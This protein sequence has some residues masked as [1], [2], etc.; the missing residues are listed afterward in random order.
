MPIRPNRSVLDAIPA[1]RWV[2]T[3]LGRG[4]PGDGLGHVAPGST[5]RRDQRRAAS[6]P[7]RWRSTSRR[8]ILFHAHRL[9]RLPEYARVRDWSVRSAFQP[10]IL[11]GR[12]LGLLGYGGVGRRAAHIA[13][14]LGMRVLAVRRS[15]GRSPAEQFRRPEIDALDAGPEPAEIRGLDALD[16]LL[17]SSDLLRFNGAA[18]GRDARA[19]RR[20]RAGA[21]AARRGGDQRLAAA[22]C[23]TR[24][25]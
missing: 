3:A 11:V 2:Q 19:H 17:S 22:R 20:A 18:D 9:W 12:T 6:R 7:S 16:W 25:R 13:A 15:P 14:A 23:S 21:A 4:Q 1:L 24:T 8:P 10:A 5:G